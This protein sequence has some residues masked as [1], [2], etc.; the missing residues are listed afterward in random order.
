MLNNNKLEARTAQQS[1]DGLH[2]DHNA[3]ALQ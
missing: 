3:R 2:Y 1:P